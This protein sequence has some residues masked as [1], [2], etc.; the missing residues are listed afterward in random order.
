MKFLFEVEGVFTPEDYANKVKIGQH[1]KLLG[2]N[3]SIAIVEIDDPKKLDEMVSNIGDKL[4]ALY[5]V[6]EYDLDF[7]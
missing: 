2:A 5:P 1:Y 7:K 6:I 4:L 3:K